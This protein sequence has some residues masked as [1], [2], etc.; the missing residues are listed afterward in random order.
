MAVGRRLSPACLLLLRLTVALVV[1]TALPE[2]A[3]ARTRRY[4][5][6]VRMHAYIRA[7]VSRAVRPMCNNALLAS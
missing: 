5:F 6:N 3:A 1:L 4:T 7:R 2:L